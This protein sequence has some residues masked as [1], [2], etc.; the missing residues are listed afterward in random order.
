RK[1]VRN[2]ASSES[3]RIDG[4]FFMR[5]DLRDRFKSL[6]AGRGATRSLGNANKVAMATGTS[7][8]DS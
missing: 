1:C 6:D 7:G 8:K 3:P 4:C 5:A 2:V